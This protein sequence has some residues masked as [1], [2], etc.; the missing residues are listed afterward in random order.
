MIQVYKYNSMTFNLQEENYR[1]VPKRFEM[2]VYLT[3]FSWV[4]TLANYGI[5]ELLIY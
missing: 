1:S 2:T 4:A 3:H 5:Y